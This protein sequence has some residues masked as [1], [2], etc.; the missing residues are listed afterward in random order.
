MG[1]PVTASDTVPAIAQLAT[2]GVGTGDGPFGGVGE[3]PL[4]PHAVRFTQHKTAVAW[5][6]R[7]MTE[8][9][10]KEGLVAG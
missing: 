5:K 7:F 3:P 2:V 1:A 10:A 6:I 4:L 9:P 8:T